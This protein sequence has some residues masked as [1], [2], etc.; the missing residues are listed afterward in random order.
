MNL[1]RSAACAAIAFGTA[2]RA[3]QLAN[4]RT[5]YTAY[6]RPAGR[7]AAGPLKVEHGIIDEIMVG[8]YVPPW[9]AFPVLGATVPTVYLK[10]RSPELGPITLSVRGGFAYL[11]DNA[12]TE[13]TD[14]EATGN[15]AS[16]TADVAVRAFGPSARRK[17]TPRRSRAH[18]PPTRTASAGS[19]NGA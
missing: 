14:G 4:P 10:L 7:M 12:V 18:R 15:A 1:A 3:D 5:D 6:T 2:A 8:T 16:T 13:L 17:A 9:V 19:A 11:D